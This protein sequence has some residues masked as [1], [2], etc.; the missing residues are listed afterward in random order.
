LD[1]LSLVALG[2]FQS[3]GCFLERVKDPIAM[4][5][6]SSRHLLSISFAYIEVP[7]VESAVVEGP[8]REGFFV[9]QFSL[10]SLS[11]WSTYSSFSI[12]IIERIRDPS[13]EYMLK[14]F[15][16]PMARQ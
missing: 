1:D 4:L 12:Q 10:T 8:E 3:I 2:V 9:D 13:G 6:K 7:D 5:A 11:F 14:A 16:Q 15:L